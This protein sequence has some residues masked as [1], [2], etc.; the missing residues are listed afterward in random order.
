[1]EFIKKSNKIVVIK[2]LSGF[3]CLI[4]LGIICNIFENRSGYLI[5]TKNTSTGNVYIYIYIYI[6]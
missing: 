6:K 1:V 3:I 2:V 5:L 4:I